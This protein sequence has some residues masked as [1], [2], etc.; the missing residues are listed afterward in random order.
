MGTVP[1]KDCPSCG[2]RIPE[3]AVT[4]TVCRSGLGR[5]SGCNLWLVIGTE[6]FDCGGST[7]IRIRK[8]AAVSAAG[9]PP[10]SVE[11]DASPMGLLP[12]LALRL[13]L[14]A[15]FLASVAV[16][17]ADAPFPQLTRITDEV[18]RLPKAGGGPAVWAAAGGL[19]VAVGACGT[20]IRR[21]RLNHTQ[22]LGKPV[23]AGFSAG[24]L[25]LDLLLTVLVLGLTAGL[26]FPWL[27]AR[28]RRSFYR[29]CRLTARGQ[30]TLDF[31]GAGEEV[32]GRIA[33][34]LL[35]LPL[36][37]A[38]GGLLFGVISWIWLKW[39]QTNLLVPDKHGQNRSP[40]FTGTF[41]AYYGRWLLG[42]LL[43]LVT[44]GVYRGWA[45]VSEWRWVA[46]CT[47]VS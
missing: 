27:Y 22:L 23:E 16:G 24:A 40:K 42:W 11:V 29:G 37:L 19:L 33:L 1:L 12:L 26:G 21:Y 46:S 34:T 25:V 31:Q 10:S 2:S 18:L 14:F 45:K 5:C 20:L 8:A 3:P 41:G 30:A 28:Y 4:C 36:A 13:L 38:T 44:A 6:C 7:A 47:Q 17:I 32:L 35:L 39:D 43:T 15:G 9:P